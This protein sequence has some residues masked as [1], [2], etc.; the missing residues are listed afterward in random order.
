MQLDQFLHE[1]EPDSAAFLGA[2][3][4]TFDAVEAVEQPRDLTRQV[5]PFRYRARSVALR[6]P[7]SRNETSI[8][9]S[10]VNLKALEMR[11]RTIFSHISRS[12]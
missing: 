6:R 7:T 2:P 12:T 9:P 3:A 5:Y 1:R 4:R 10:N 8:S 11:L